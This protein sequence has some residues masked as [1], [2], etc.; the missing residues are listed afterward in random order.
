MVDRQL[1]VSLREAKRRLVEMGS[2]VEKAIYQAVQSL[3]MQNVQLAEWVIE[4]DERIDQLEG[5]IDELVVQ[6]IATQQPVAKDLRKLIAMMK[7]ATDL[8]RMADLAV[9]V[10]HVTIECEQ[11]EIKLNQEWTEI[12]KMAQI[13]E[14]MVRDAIQS[15]L[16]SDLL[17]AQSLAKL[18]DQVDRRYHQTL[19]RLIQHLNHHPN[20]AEM[21]I[22]LSLAIRFLERIADHATNIAESIHFIETGG[23]T[24]LN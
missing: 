1:H 24:D 8:E 18:D 15:Y 7:I 12:M 4:E 13:S 11:K 6:L 17:L 14:Q 20:H 9:N 5:Q 19:E 22:H 2:Y 16:E 21:V 3:V 10:A 23:R